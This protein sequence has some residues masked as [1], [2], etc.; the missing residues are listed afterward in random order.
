M[1]RQQEP[2]VYDLAY[3]GKTAAVKILLNENQKLKSET[4][5]VNISLK[6]FCFQIWLVML[7]FSCAE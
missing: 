2:T 4:D 3:R 7:L 6:I 5:E 1:P